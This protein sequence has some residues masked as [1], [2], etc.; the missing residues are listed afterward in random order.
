MDLQ[1]ILMGT[2]EALFRNYFMWIIIFSVL[3][4][5]SFYIYFFPSST[6]FGYD[7]FMDVGSQDKKIPMSR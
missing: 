6:P 1:A 7:G 3:Y 2:N 4:L 5:F